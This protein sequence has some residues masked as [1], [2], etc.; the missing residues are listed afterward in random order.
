MIVI[1]DTT[2]LNYLILIGHSEVLP[3]LYG[4]VIIPKAVYE[5]LQQDH[6]PAAVRSQIAAR[7]PWLEVQQVQLGIDPKLR[8]LD[9]GEQ[10][11]IMLAEELRADLLILD[12]KDGRN[13]ATAR[14]LTVTGTVGVLEQAAKLNLL[15]LLT[16]ISKLRQTTFRADEKLL[17]AVLER[18]ARRKKSAQ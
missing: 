4:R 16:A 3:K 12:E 5:E 8:E 2:P 17:N 1:A 10:Q 14:R 15:D 18:D 6:T 9:L 11:A 13:A 7:P